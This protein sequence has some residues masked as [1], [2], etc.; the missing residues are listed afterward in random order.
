MLLAV[1]MCTG[2]GVSDGDTLKAKCTTVQ[3]HESLIVRLAEVDAPEKRQPVGQRSKRHL[4]ELFFQKEA[5]VRVLSRDRCGRAVA[6]VTCDGTD[7]NASMV[8]LGMAWA[9]TQYLTDEQLRAMEVLAQRERILAIRK[10]GKSIA[11]ES[12][13][14]S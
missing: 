2:V 7:A 9:Y 12:S 11:V 14:I 3:G 1:L 10:F 6:R 5:E 13:C 4:S 8:R